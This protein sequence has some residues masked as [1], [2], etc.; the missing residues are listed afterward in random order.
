MLGNLLQRI[1]I[2]LCLVAAAAL[3]V[4]ILMA[5]NPGAWGHIGNEMHGGFKE[6]FGA[7]GYMFQQIGYGVVILFC[8]GVVLGIIWAS[9]KFILPAAIDLKHQTQARV[10]TPSKYGPA[11]AVQYID[12]TGQV[13]FYDLANT[14]MPVDAGQMMAALKASMQAN[15]TAIGTIARQNKE[16]NM[17]ASPSEEDE[18][19]SVEGSALT[20]PPKE[21]F[22][23]SK[24]LYE[25]I[26]ADEYIIGYKADGRMQGKLFE[27]EGNLYNSMYVV[28]DQGFGKTVI[29]TLLAAYT[30]KAGGRL[31]IIDPEMG[32]PQSLTNRLGPLARPEFLLAP[33]ANTPEKTQAVL[34]QAKAEIETPGPYPVL[35]LIDELS[36]IGRHVDSKRGRW[37]DVGNDILDTTEDFATRGRKRK[38]RAI[39]MGQFTQAARSGGTFLRNAMALV[40]FHL[41]EQQAR[42][43]LGKEDAEITPLLD[44]GEAV[45]VPSDPTEPK[46]CVKVVLPDEEALDLIVKIALELLTEECRSSVVQEPQ[47]DEFTEDLNQSRTAP[48]PIKMS[49]ELA[50]KARVRRVR[51]LRK[52]GR[53]QTEIIEFVWGVSRG[54]SDAYAKAR[55]E[56]LTIM[57]RLVLEDAQEA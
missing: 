22:P 7:L 12:R 34:K 24:V 42:L 21:V 40:V 26:P 8:V 36:M 49:P 41:K 33:V 13:A 56:Y 31:L 51:E 45:I 14:S 38:R 28:G 52:Q 32:D 30:I 39:V 20:L 11:Q 37:A 19:D 55:D 27:K 50:Y 43:A 53:N 9:I 57:Q 5:A 18:D 2:I 4:L 25:R 44:K 15:Y 35:L 1:T 16:L 6:F 46:A 10:I 29:A 23:L 3:F 54:G 47:M 17:I 48:E